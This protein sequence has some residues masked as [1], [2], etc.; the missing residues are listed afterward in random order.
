MALS[1]NIEF[2]IRLLSSAETR[3]LRVGLA[4]SRLRLLPSR[5]PLVSSLTRGRGS[6]SYLTAIYRIDT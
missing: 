1:P 6:H 4:S 5:V 2:V 3:S